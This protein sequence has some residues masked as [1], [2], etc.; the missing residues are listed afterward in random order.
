MGSS[1]ITVVLC[2]L[3]LCNRIVDQ[4]MMLAHGEQET[5]GS[6]AAGGLGGFLYLRML[7]RSVDAYGA[8]PSSPAGLVGAMTSNNR[9]LV[10]FLLALAFNRC[11]PSANCVQTVFTDA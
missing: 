6:Y 7:Q 5:A 8:A 3:V 11:G 4:H 2:F 10:P 9:M 1:H